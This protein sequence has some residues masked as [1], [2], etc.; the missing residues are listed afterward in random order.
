MSPFIHHLFHVDAV[1]V[2]VRSYPLEPDDAFLEINSNHQA[3]IVTPDVEHN[4][5]GTHDTCGRVVTL[6]VRY[7]PPARPVHLLIPSIESGAQCGLILVA[8]TR[9]DEV[10]QRAPRDYSHKPHLSCAQIGRKKRCRCPSGVDP[11][12]GSPGSRSCL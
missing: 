12:C 5:L 4:S 8:D 9:G 6:H 3:I 11:P 10:P 1:I 7:T 2:S